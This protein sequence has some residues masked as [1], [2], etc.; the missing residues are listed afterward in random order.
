MENEL[1]KIIEEKLSKNKDEIIT[2]LNENIK[3]QEMEIDENFIL[4]NFWD[5]F[6]NSKGKY[7]IVIPA[8]QRNYVQGND[9]AIRSN[10]IKDIFDVLKNDENKYV[11][12]D[13]IYGI[14]Y[15]NKFVPI[16][17]QQRLTTLFLLYWYVLGKENSFSLLRK[18]NFTYENRQSSKEFFELLNNLDVT[19][20][21]FEQE[22]GKISEKIRNSI[23][24]YSSKWNKDLTIQSALKMLDEIEEKYNACNDNNIVNKLINQDKP[25]IIFRCKFL[26]AQENTDAELYI[27]MNSRGKKLSEYEILKSKLESIAYK[28]INDKDQY[29]SLCSNLDNT[30]ANKFL[31][32]VSH[33]NV[34][35]EENHTYSRLERVENNYFNFLKKFIIFHFLDNALEIEG[36]EMKQF[37]DEL[38]GNVDIRFEEEGIYSINEDFF[39]KLDNI[40]Q[41]IEFLFSNHPAEGCNH[42]KEIMDL[43]NLWK[44]NIEGNTRYLREELYFYA[45]IKYLENSKLTE[46]LYINYELFENW[47]RITRN[48]IN[49]N[50]HIQIADRS[51]EKDDSIYFRIA[52][53]IKKIINE[54]E[55]TN[56]HNILR[57]INEQTFEYV[58]QSETTWIK[59]EKLKAQYILKTDNPEWK[60]AIIEAD[61]DQY[62]RG[63]NYFLFKLI[64]NEENKLE[65]F[66]KYQKV[67]GDIF[68]NKQEQLDENNQDEKDDNENKQIDD[69]LIQR[70]M[71]TKEDYFTTNNKIKIFYVFNYTDNTNTWLAILN[72]KDKEKEKEANIILNKLKN[73]IDNDILENMDYKNINVTDKLK[74]IINNSYIKQNDWRYYFIKDK[75]LFN[76]CKQGNIE[77]L[78]DEENEDALNANRKLNLINTQKNSKQWDYLTKLLEYVL[79]DCFNQYSKDNSKDVKITV[80]YNGTTGTSVK[81][82]KYN[83]HLKL[84]IACKETTTSKKNIIKEYTFVRKENGK[85]KIHLKDNGE[86]YFAFNYD[87]TLNNRE[88]SDNE[89]EEF[90]NNFKNLDD[91]EIIYNH[92]LL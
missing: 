32:K 7:K 25:K 61:K 20:K 59:Y 10:I 26:D 74:Q 9:K 83:D 62:F 45:I 37:K 86:Q 3:N 27:K 42:I 81:E 51:K 89:R 1:I 28:Y 52:K 82:T 39:N 19:R 75:R 6:N 48:Y 47:I 73:F 41:N 64:E 22:E 72:N 87:I 29:M 77:Y 84:I 14:N 50:Y 57:Y 33:D 35:K 60:D 63:V 76:T 44:I 8:I 13:I 15:E 11:N 88:L 40:M 16:D 66:K 90:L 71:L 24:F 5:F 30:W 2:L 54:L 85:Y 38:Q 18:I 31:Q 55:N 4:T 68:K 69:F 80:Q 58:T 91:I 12:L 78:P 56:H 67:I 46:N 23:S 65:I 92:N 70:A 49:N 79:K 43:D 21:I 53:N 36:P 34:S 17:G